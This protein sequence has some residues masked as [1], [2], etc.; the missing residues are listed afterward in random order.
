MGRKRTLAKRTG[1]V[2]PYKVEQ[3]GN[4]WVVINADTNDVKGT[5]T[6]PDAEEKARKQMKLLNAIE[7]GWEPSK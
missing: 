5:H 3:R 6:E 4:E 7:H 1:K 2:M